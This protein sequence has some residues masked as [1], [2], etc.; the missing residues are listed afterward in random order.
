[1]RVQVDLR[2]CRNNALCVFTAPEVF[3][4]DEMGQLTFHQA[5][6]A[7]YTSEALPDEVLDA[8][9]EAAISCPTQAISLI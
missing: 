5:G 3:T 4:A 8:V 1:M 2:K 6:G 7:E 9:E